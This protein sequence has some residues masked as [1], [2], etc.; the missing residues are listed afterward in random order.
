LEL[1]KIFY[2][3]EEAEIKYIAAINLK[4]IDPDQSEITAPIQI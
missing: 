3:S 1:L 2:T 4:K